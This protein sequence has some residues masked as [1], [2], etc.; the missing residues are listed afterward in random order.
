LYCYV[1]LNKMFLLI[2]TNKNSYEI[3]KL[4]TTLFSQKIIDNFYD[5]I[6]TML[7]AVETLSKY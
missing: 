2:S 3:G 6:E 7:K 1:Y 5:E 4:N